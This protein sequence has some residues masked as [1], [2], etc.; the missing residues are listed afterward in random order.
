MSSRT[1][2]FVT[3][4][5]GKLAEAKAILSASGVNLESKNVEITEIQGTIEEITR[6]KAKRAAEQI[7]GPIIVEDTCLCFD[8]LKGLPGPYVKHFLKEIG[9]RGLTNMLAAY[10]DKTAYAVCTFAYCE[11]GS[12][13]IL[14]EGRT[15]GKVVRARG[16]GSFGW[17]PIFEYEGSTYAEMDSYQKNKISHR[18]KAL[19]KL[20]AWL[21]E[22]HGG[23]SG[24][25]V[26]PS[27]APK[28]VDRRNMGG[29]DTSSDGG[30]FFD[31]FGEEVKS[32]AINI[33]GDGMGIRKAAGRE[34][35][36]DAPEGG[37]GKY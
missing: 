4:N 37:R 5:A 3:S 2:F 22:K 15:K 19:Q 35:Q 30:S 21:E 13:P 26:P 23:G 17:D 18:F 7:G 12:E 27:A 10:D 9:T 29:H 33:A 1:L 14:F 6:D 36:F 8:A 28:P 16:E 20:T 11:P 24:G 31:G 34:W 25:S 32:R